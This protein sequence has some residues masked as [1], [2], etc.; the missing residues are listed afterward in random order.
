MELAAFTPTKHFNRE[1]H[2][3]CSPIFTACCR[4][5]SEKCPR[6][7]QYAAERQVCVDSN[8]AS[9]W[10]S[11]TW[12]SQRSF[13]PDILDM[14]W[15]AWWINGWTCGD[16]VNAR[17]PTIAHYCPLILQT[18][19]N[20]TARIRQT[21][22]SVVSARSRSTLSTA[23]SPLRCPNSSCSTATSS[24]IFTSSCEA[25]ASGNSLIFCSFCPSA[26]Y[27]L[28]LHDLQKSWT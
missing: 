21:F 3:A 27:S 12:Y 23:A 6:Y 15:L 7:V 4:T 8:A 18:E 13:S 25:K 1:G 28:A 24:S 19:K 26:L 17:M 22:C 10:I 16:L 14:R 2:V 11:A 20:W 9:L 5:S